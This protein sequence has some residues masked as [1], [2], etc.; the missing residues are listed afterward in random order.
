MTNDIRDRAL[1]LR[2][3]EGLG[4]RQAAKRRGGREREGRLRDAIARVKEQDREVAAEQARRDAGA[5]A[6]KLAVE[7]YELEQRIEA[8]GVA[9]NR[10]IAALE[11]LDR[12]QRAALRRSGR[13]PGHD[14]SLAVLLPRWFAHR[15]GGFGRITGVPGGHPSGKDRPL[16]ERDPMASGMTVLGG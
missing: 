11:A 13:N 6:E 16:P 12:R 5:E 9:L 2:E 1:D 4:N 7:R 3:Q 8:E 14:H 10:S 15:F